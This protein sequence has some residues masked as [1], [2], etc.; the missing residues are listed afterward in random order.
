MWTVY[1]MPK[2]INVY[3][4]VLTPSAS[5]CQQ[6]RDRGKAGYFQICTLN[7]P[8]LEAGHLIVHMFYYYISAECSMNF[9]YR[10]HDYFV[11]NK[12]SPPTNSCGWSDGG[13]QAFGSSS[14]DACYFNIASHDPSDTTE[15]QGSVGT[16]SQSNLT[17][18]A[19]LSQGGTPTPLRRGAIM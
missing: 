14:T 13:F 9:S 4:T 7:N 11:D 3:R 15:G 8:D 17:L 10:G 18:G 12:Q 2:G 1:P 19:T 16:L 6:D 5:D